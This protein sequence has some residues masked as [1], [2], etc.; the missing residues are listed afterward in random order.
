MAIEYKQEEYYSLD[1]IEA[2]LSMALGSDAWEN[3]KKTD[4]GQN[5]IKFASNA[6]HMDAMAFFTGLNQM[7]R[8]TVTQ[9]GYMEEIAK[10]NGVIPK[11]Y[12]SANITV[13]LYSKDNI[14]SFLPLDFCMQVGGKKFYNVTDITI[15]TSSNPTTLVLYEGS[16]I[17]EASE[18]GQAL[19]V[20]WT[21]TKYKA[22]QS[23]KIGDRIVRKYLLLPR[24]LYVDSLIVESSVDWDVPFI[25]WNKVKTW[26]GVKNTDRAWKL[27]KDMLGRYTVEFGDG[28]YGREYP[29]SDIVG[30][31]YILS[32]GSGVTVDNF[33]S[34]KIYGQ[35]I[36]DLSTTFT[37]GSISNLVD[38]T[39]E[40]NMSDLN[41]EIEQAQNT[42]DSLINEDDY[43]NYLTSRADVL[44]ANV[45]AERHNNPPNIEYF[46]TVKYMIKPNA[47]GG[48]FNDA[49]ILEY[50]GKK[51][52]KTVEFMKTN[53]KIGKFNITVKFE[54]LA[55]FTPSGINSQI[56]SILTNAFSWTS[57]G[58]EETLSRERVYSLIKDIDGLNTQTLEI[59]V[60]YIYTNE[61]SGDTSF[62][63]INGSEV[64]LRFYPRRF[65]MYMESDALISG[66]IARDNGSGKLYGDFTDLE[67]F[68]ISGTDEGMYPNSFCFGGL[69]FMCSGTSDEAFIVDIRKQNGAVS[70]LKFKDIVLNSTWCDRYNELVTIEYSTS[71]DTYYLRSYTFP[72]SFFDMGGFSYIQL[73]DIHEYTTTKKELVLD[74]PVGSLLPTCSVYNDSYIYVV[75][76]ISGGYS[77]LYRYRTMAGGFESRDL[78][79]NGTGFLELSEK[80]CKSLVCIQDAFRTNQNVLFIATGEGSTNQTCL[81][82]VI[83]F[84]RADICVYEK[85]FFR[86][87]LSSLYTLPLK[88]GSLSTDGDSLYAP[89]TSTN[90]GG[91]TAIVKLYSLNEDGTCNIKQLSDASVDKL[92]NASYYIYN[93]SAKVY[94]YSGDTYKLYTVDF[95]ALN[96]APTKRA[97]VS[98]GNSTSIKKIA[99]IDYDMMKLVLA[100]DIEGELRYESENPLV[101]EK[102]EMPILNTVTIYNK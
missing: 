75:W 22:V 90:T 53:V 68:N 73:V 70:K 1:A 44:F 50:L 10:S 16:A 80:V 3:V 23:E 46:N 27:G 26:H 91:K 11:T 21:Y 43:K 54:A 79:Y 7:F 41:L 71:L 84:D 38:G 25:R 86:I 96:V 59:S 47:P 58:F 20:S 77:S 62:S 93:S 65:K 8:S 32:S 19:G 69:M 94:T 95:D 42:R 87:T 12:I 31:R 74:K 14:R 51:G 55:G 99:D 64:E 89:L 48:L 49:E 37:V 6:I 45:Q 78:A 82:C 39:S 28:I 15:G 56:Q 35:D 30:I 33:N 61:Q 18:A 83:D 5:L 34:F 67:R 100:L 57:L 13:S 98:V 88:F 60:E 52:L 85:D 4:L 36:N 24:E 76:S 40:I 66:T 97:G 81:D 2:R 92:M 29:T 102:E 101:Y 9:Q 17:R 72:E 63:F